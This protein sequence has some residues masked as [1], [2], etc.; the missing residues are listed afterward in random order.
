[1]N[2][3]TK[4]H[5][6]HKVKLRNF[7]SH[8]WFSGRWK[9]IFVM[10]VCRLVDGRN[11]SAYHASCICR[12]EVTSRRQVAGYEE[13]VISG[14]RSDVDKICALLGYY[15]ALTSSS[16]PKFRDNLSVLSSGPT[17]PGEE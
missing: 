14:F 16:I 3:N 10:T 17:S 7:V 6:E 15:A 9:L 1:M 5:G 13:C 2:I 4:M 8:L 12:G 11:I